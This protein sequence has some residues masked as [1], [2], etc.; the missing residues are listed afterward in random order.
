MII[1]IALAI[2]EGSG[3]GPITTGL[4]AD[5]TTDYRSSTIPPI[6]QSTRNSSII[7]YEEVIF[8]ICSS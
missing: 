7:K 4:K 8:S 3:L 2:A 5:P 1:K 6:F